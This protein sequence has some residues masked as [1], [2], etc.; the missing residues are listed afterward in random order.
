MS[1]RRTVSSIAPSGVAGG[2]CS[3][4]EVSTLMAI[5]LVHVGARRQV[6]DMRLVR[7]EMGANESIRVG[8]RQPGRVPMVVAE[9][10]HAGTRL[11]E[12]ESGADGNRFLCADVI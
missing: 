1:R 5:T 11:T 12:G 9:P 10:A 4:C 6:G 3:D 2:C 7:M 8:H